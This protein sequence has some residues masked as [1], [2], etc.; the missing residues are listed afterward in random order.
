LPGIYSA[1]SSDGIRFDFEG[2]AFVDERIA[3]TDASVVQIEKRWHIYA[4]DLGNR[5][6][7]GVS[8]D[9]RRFVRDEGEDFSAL[10]LTITRMAPE[11]GCTPRDAIARP[12]GRMR[13][14]LLCRPPEKNWATIATVVTSDGRQ[15]EP[16]D[17]V[18]LVDRDDS[19]K[20]LLVRGAAITRLSD[21]GFVLAYIAPIP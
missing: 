15:F 8:D 16:D 21:D 19:R 11:A 13:F 2:A 4:I 20:G 7:H 9:G 18:R 14:L 12:D 3:F 6:W 10:N 1:R 5:I 17:S